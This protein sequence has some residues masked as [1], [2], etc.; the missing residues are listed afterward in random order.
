MTAKNQDRI[1][2]SRSGWTIRTC[3]R[4]KLGSVT[5][6]VYDVEHLCGARQKMSFWIWRWSRLPCARC[7]LGPLMQFEL[8]DA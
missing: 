2:Q 5:S 8:E 1:G 4:R 3:T 7:Q 6:V